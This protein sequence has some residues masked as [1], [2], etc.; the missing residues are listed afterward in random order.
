MFDQIFPNLTDRNSS[1]ESPQTTRYNCVAWAVHNDLMNIWP[2]A[3][4]AWPIGMPRDET[5]EGMV[6]FFKQLGFEECPDSSFESGFEKIAIYAR[7]SVPQH[8]ARQKS[9]GRW[10]SKLNVLADIWH[11]SPDVLECG[12]M[13]ENGYGSVVKIMRRQ[14]DGRPPVLPPMHPPPPIIIRL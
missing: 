2:D 7:N 11:S 12:D 14:N 6:A 4:N 9:D 1:A 5:V 8:V 10:T 13:I 3:D